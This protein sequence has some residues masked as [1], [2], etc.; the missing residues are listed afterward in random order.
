MNSPA[1]NI[2][3][4]TFPGFCLLTAML[5]F[6]LNDGDKTRES[7][8]AF[9]F[10]HGQ[11]VQPITSES[12]ISRTSSKII[13][14]QGAHDLT[15]ARKSIAGDSKACI[16][17]INCYNIKITENKLYRSADVGIRLYNCKNVRI[18]HNY[19]SN[20]STGV[21]AEKTNEGGIKVD[22]NWFLNMQ[23]PYP[24]G[25]F[26]QFNNINGPGNV[27]ADNRCENVLGESNPEDAI[28]LYKS[29]GTA[30][31]PIIIK[32]NW[33]RGG[34]PSRSGGGIMLGDNGG[35]YQTAVENK[36]V[37]PGQY[38]IAISGGHHN[39]IIGNFIYARCQPFTNVG[40][41]VAGYNGSACTNSTVARNKVRYFNNKHSENNAWVSPGIPKPSGW[42][43]NSW[44]ASIDSGILPHV[45]V[46]VN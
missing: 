41:Y 46:I 5:I 37:D 44:G 8:R 23:G 1:P 33:I 45:I 3:F 43:T 10:I 18:S 31:S 32:G 40:L 19:F 7:E 27:I 13:Y 14:L 42:E 34:G 16:T 24:R 30:L 29:N 25:Q 15:I 9:S 28:S 39:S 35:S 6:S 17:L 20:L 11:R 38:G 36:L 12:Q 21:Y 22:H 4:I 26:A 2:I